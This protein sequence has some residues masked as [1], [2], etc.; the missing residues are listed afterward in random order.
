MSEETHYAPLDP[1]TVKPAFERNNIAVFFA[2]DN[3]YA[4]LL[5]VAVASA[6]A[7]GSVGNN[8]DFLILDDNITNIN[9]KKIATSIAGRPNCYLRFLDSAACFNRLD[10]SFWHTSLDYSRIVN[11][12]LF[13]ASIF[14]GYDKIIYLDCDLIVMTDLAELFHTDLEGQPLG[15]ARDFGMM[16]INHKSAKVAGYYKKL[17]GWDSMTDYFN[18]GVMVLDLKAMRATSLEDEFL[19]QIKKLTRPLYPN[20]DVLNPVC[21][22]RVKYLDPAWNVLEPMAGD[23]DQL[24]GW[25]FI[26]EPLR[27]NGLRAGLDPKIIHF[28]GR[29]RP[30]LVNRNYSQVDHHFWQY[31]RLTPYYERLLTHSTPDFDLLKTAANLP[32]LKFRYYRY[33]LIAFL[34][35]GRISAK[36]RLR[37]QKL[38]KELDRLKRSF[39]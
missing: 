24:T 20:Q 32:W 11:V 33:A 10:P 5:G 28:V 34:P 8:Y 37:K 39:R 2:S 15:A 18:S 35:L 12:R 21:R 22:G 16:K 23:P 17:L 19:T 25:D 31:A 6:A 3:N 4:P 1:A 7:N 27:L 29:G 9:R 38:K 26:P 36:Y 30:W 13:A 14:P